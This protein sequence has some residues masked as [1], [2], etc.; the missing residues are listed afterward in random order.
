MLAVF[1]TASI[2]LSVVQASMPMAG[3]AR[4]SM[5]MPQMAGMDQPQDNVCKHC[6][7]DMSGKALACGLI[8]V[9]A[10]TAD[11]QELRHGTKLSN[12]RYL[13]SNS[14]MTGRTLIPEPYP[15]RP[16]AFI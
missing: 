3:P 16:L 1:V 10:L 15:P 13:N 8:V 6:P 5:A 11:A 4:M 12:I 14:V 9:C 7:G 2:S